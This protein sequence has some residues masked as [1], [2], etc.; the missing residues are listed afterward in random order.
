MIKV[1]EEIRS[2]AM[3]VE[4]ELPG[5]PGMT[6]VGW[7]FV[8]VYEH[9]LGSVHPTVRVTVFKP[10]GILVIPGT[11]LVQFITIFAMMLMLLEHAAPETCW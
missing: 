1:S 10:A 3:V 9:P 8:T 7:L 5:E 4:V 6:G 11:A 2:V